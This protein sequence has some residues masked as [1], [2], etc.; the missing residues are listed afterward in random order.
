MT[1]K[2]KI[3]GK[4]EYLEGFVAVIYKAVREGDG[5][6]VRELL[7]KVYEDGFED[8]MYEGTLYGRTVT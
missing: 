7:D 2:K 5:D 4:D 3:Q 6:L 8:G 1:K